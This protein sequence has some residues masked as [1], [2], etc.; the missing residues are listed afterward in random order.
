MFK[1]YS[2]VFDVHFAEQPVNAL[3]FLAYTAQ[4]A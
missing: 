3:E 4:G 1:N 2:R